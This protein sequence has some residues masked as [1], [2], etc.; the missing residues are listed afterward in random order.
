MSSSRVVQVPPKTMLLLLSLM[1]SLMDGSQAQQ[2]DYWLK[3]EESVTVQEGLCVLVPCSFSYPKEPWN[4]HPVYGYWF[5]EGTHTE[6]GDPVATNNPSRNLLQN[7]EGQFQLVGDLRKKDCALLIRDV[8][9]KDWGLY[10]FR[11]E[12]GNQVKYNFKDNKFLLRVT[13]LTQKPDVF[14]P[15]TLDP[16]QPVTVLCVF[17]WSSEQCPAPIFSWEGPTLTS[18]GTRAPGAPYSILSFTPGPQDQDSALTCRVDF[19]RG[20]NTQRTVRL[21]V[22]YAPK[23]PV[24]SIFHDNGSV[25]ESQENNPHVEAE[26]GQLLQL[27]C[28]AESRPPATLTWEL[29]G[30]VLSQSPPSAPSPLRLELPGVQPVDAG[31]YTCRAENSLGSQHRSLDLAVQYPPEDLRVTVSRANSTVL[32]IL[33]NGTSLPVLEGQS[34]RLVCV[35]H[36][37]PPARL[38]WAR[39]TQALSPSWPS[40]PGVLELPRVQLEHEGEVSCHAENALGTR[41]VSLS[42]SV[43]YA[44][45]LLGPWC[46][47]EAEAL[48]CSCSSQARPAPALHW[49]LGQGLLEGNSSNASFTV[50]SSSAGPWANSSLSLRGGLR[51][52]LRLH[53]EAQNVH[54][55]Q[56]AAVLLLPDKTP[57]ATSFSRG[58]LLGIGSTALLSLCLVLIL[59]KVRRTTHSQAETPGPKFSRSSTILDYINV[60]PKVRSLARDRK[61]MPSSPSQMPSPETHSPVWKKNP[62]EPP[63]VSRVCSEPKTSTGTPDSETSPEELHYATINFPGLRPWQTQPPKGT[64]QDYAEIKFYHGSPGL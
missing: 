32:E 15:E 35:T 31:R 42:L 27:L 16:G 5:K 18:E 3:V 34:L 54:G 6:N 17:N 13:D 9:R 12:K 39:G 37:H 10:F 11:V 36:S 57:T 50:T 26:K 47:W 25:Q 55:V 51:S 56:G 24:I 59:V 2:K 58:V 53:C 64:H 44:P 46:S 4:P 61:V 40:A 52:G 60:V 49:R 63:L 41:S 48:H 29:R 19:S 45:Q 30:R 8:Q 14:I 38:R 33:G 22:A 20:L 1:S 43:H 28:A 23:H 62:K 7:T 21:S